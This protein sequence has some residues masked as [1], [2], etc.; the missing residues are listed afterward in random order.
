MDYRETPPPPGLDGFVAAI[1]TLDVGGAPG[2]WV[3][4]EAVP[5]G[6]IELI[7]RH[8]GRSVWRTEQP[9]L[10]VTGLALRPA[11]LRFSGDARFTAI[12][13][14]PWGWHALG[15]SRCAD[16]ADDWQ[17]IAED[18]PFAALL[19][20]DGAHPAR[21]TAAFA[22]QPPHPID[23]IRQVEGVGALARRSGLSPRQIQRIF[24]R[25]IGMPPRSYLR[26]LRFREAVAGVQGEAARLAD[27][28]AASGYADQ[29]HMT[30][31][32]RALGGLSPGTTR[33]RAA[34]PFVAARDEPT[35][36]G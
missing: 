19:P 2:D 30:R 24:A 17:G 31:E 28:A 27:M 23:L 36:D 13:L 9:P 3:P 10:F 33:R 14:W 20:G 35:M 11:A 32:F 7:R 16:F 34:G 22:G 4:H 29:A 12:R 5:D 21:L 26:L 8:A 6:C 18:S 15:G 1:W 25:E